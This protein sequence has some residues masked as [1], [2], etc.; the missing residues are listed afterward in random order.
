MLIRFIILC[1]FVTSVLGQ[2]IAH[3]DV[4]IKGLLAVE[5]ESYFI[6]LQGVNQRLRAKTADAMVQARLECLGHGD[7]IS[8]TALR[9]NQED[10]VISSINY[11]GLRKLIGTWRNTNEIFKFTD[12]KTFYYWNFNRNTGSNTLR[13][14]FAFHYAISPYGDTP[15]QCHWKIFFIDSTSVILGSLEW[16]DDDQIQILL[17]DSDTGEISTSKR[18]IRSVF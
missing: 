1:S 8:G 15:K 12:F 11:V 3:A 5:N 9:L 4:Q 14:P 16:I 6:Q 10:V 7:F 2:A 17:Y 13:G 18:L